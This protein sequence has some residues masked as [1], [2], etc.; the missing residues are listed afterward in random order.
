MAGRLVAVDE[1][2]A[3]IREVV[4][5]NPRVYFD[6]VEAAERSRSPFLEEIASGLD[7]QE[8]AEAIERY[9]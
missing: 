3:R 4:E 2:S 7:G 8:A 6:A 5:A 9:L 1:A